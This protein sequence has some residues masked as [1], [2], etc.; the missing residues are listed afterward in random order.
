MTKVCGN[1]SYAF[2]WVANVPYSHQ[3]LPSSF[4]TTS[5]VRNPATY[6]GPPARTYARMF[7]SI[8]LNSV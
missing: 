5:F 2:C 6:A 4:S 1:P 8:V 7:P 3:Y